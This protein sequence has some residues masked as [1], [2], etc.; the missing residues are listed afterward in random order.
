MLPAVEDQYG[1]RVGPEERTI[2]GIS[3]GGAAAVRWLLVRP[4]LFGSA[5]LLSPAVY[6]PFPSMNSSARL[7]GAFGVGATLFDPHRFRA[8]MSYPT[9]LAARPPNPLPTRVV[10]LAGDEEPAQWNETIRCDLDL[11]AVRLHVTLKERADF[12]SSLRIVAGGH[13]WAVWERG[14]VDVLRRLAA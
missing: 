11:E 5:V 7:T 2:G 9:L 10:I 1:P 4:E 6:E 3:M 8:L 13:D 12:R 14:I